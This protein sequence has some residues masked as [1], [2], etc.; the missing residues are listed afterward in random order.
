MK[1]PNFAEGIDNLPQFSSSYRGITPVLN[2]V[3]EPLSTFF[4]FQT[5]GLF[6]NQGEVDAHATQEGAAPGRFRFRDLDG[7]GVIDL[8]DRTSIGN[9]IPDFNGGITFKATYRNWEVEVY[10]Y[11]VL[12]NEI[13]MM[14]NC[15][16][17]FIRCSQELLSV[18]EC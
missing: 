11:A 13:F 12:G 5:D 7:N 9:P 15:L 16:L 8:N 6:A 4:G 18:K 1:L 2:Q 3:G 14:S 10:G 17:T